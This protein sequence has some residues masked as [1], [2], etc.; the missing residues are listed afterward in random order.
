ML[1]SLSTGTTSNAPTIYHIYLTA[2]GER[3][4]S[5]ISVAIYFTRTVCSEISQ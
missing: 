2:L 1:S 4:D 3:C 5:L